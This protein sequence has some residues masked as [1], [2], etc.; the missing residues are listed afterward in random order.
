M[1]SDGGWVCDFASAEI[2]TRQIF[3]KPIA[4]SGGIRGSTDPTMTGARTTR[5]KLYQVGQ[6]V[7]RQAKAHRSPKVAAKGKVPYVTKAS[8]RRRNRYIWRAVGL[9][10]QSR[11]TAIDESE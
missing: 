8:S 6:R 1:I 7:A 10:Q 3:D 2:E 11:A 4:V 5:T 9:S